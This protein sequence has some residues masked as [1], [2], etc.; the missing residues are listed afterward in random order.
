M[1]S[2]SRK[3]WKEIKINHNI[4]EKY[5]QD[6]NLSE[7]ISKIIIS[8]NFNL[9]EIYTINNELDFTN[10]FKNIEDFKISTKILVDAINNKE[11]ICILGDYDVDGSASTALFVKFFTKINHPHYYYIPDRERDGYGATKKLFKKLIL[12]KPKLVIMVDCGSNSV[13]A[14]NYLNQNNIKS[15]II[16]HHEINKPY[17]LANI[18]INPKKDNGY[19]KYDYLCATTLTYFF[20]D[21]LIK[22]I[23]LKFIIKDYLIYVLM[24]TICDVMPLRNINRLIAIN[25]L[26]NFKIN[27]NNVLKKIYNIKGIRNNLT[28]DDI[29]YLIGPILNSGGRLGKSEY[30][31]EL[32]SSNNDEIINK[33]ANDLIILNEKRKKIEDIIVKEINFD[34]IEKENKNIIIIYK[35]NI[36]EGLIGIIAARLKEYFNKPSLVIT[37]SNNYLKGSARSVNNFKIGSII[38]NAL[39]QDLLISGGGHNMAAGFT[40]KK[41]K[42]IELEKFLFETYD[43]HNIQKDNFSYYNAK[44]SSIAF[45]KNFYSI[46]KKI[47][48]FGNNNPEPIFLFEDLK[49]IKTKIISNK[50]LSVIFKSKIGYSVNSISFNSINT[51]IGDCLLNYKKKLSVIG[52]IKENFW[53]NKYSIQLIIKDLLI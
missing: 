21:I 4:I 42:L 6:Y 18:I 34:K 36:N 7:T 22:K 52:Q 3:N 15:I 45:N 29:G 28:V 50:H 26:Q 17:P 38:R 33:R 25:V 32:L 14:I 5:K 44:I 2:V 24:A 35:K 12:K 47:E 37:D 20:L 41:H 40:L 11:K 27:K 51:K 9:D 53:N 30:A 13:E 23:N 19:K 49:I 16:D 46:I 10:V 43:K 1:I 31:T 39:D 8:R 48:P